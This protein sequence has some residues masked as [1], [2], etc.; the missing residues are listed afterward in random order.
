MAPNLKIK[1]HTWVKT[2]RTMAMNKEF[3]RLISI[4]EEEEEESLV[5]DT[6]QYL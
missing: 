5:C 4:Q 6:Y 1:F 2:A 3:C